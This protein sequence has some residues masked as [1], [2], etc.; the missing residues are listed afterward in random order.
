VTDAG[1]R[2]LVPEDWEALLRFRERLWPEGEYHLDRSYWEWN[3]GLNPHASGRPD[4]LSWAALKDGAVIAEAQVQPVVLSCAGRTFPGS[5]CME[6]Y[7]LPEARKRGL[8]SA[9]VGRWRSGGGL[10]LVMEP[11]RHSRPIFLASGCLP[12]CELGSWVSSVT[13]RARWGRALASVLRP[14]RLPEMKAVDRFEPAWDPVWEAARG[15]AAHIRRDHPWLNWRFAFQPLVRFERVVFFHSGSPCG[16]AVFR[17]PLQAEGRLRVADLAALPEALEGI[18]ER[19]RQ[20]AAGLGARL[21]Q[22]PVSSPSLEPG[23][24]KAGMR[25]EGPYRCVLLAGEPFQD[26]FFSSADADQEHPV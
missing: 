23:L 13:P 3:T 17:L 2:P 8:G 11:S 7:T 1:I 5:W 20:R 24:R 22:F 26:W 9:L 6:L 14:R 15:A 10:H 16:Y 4:P 21:L 12:W 25:M 18:L 19:C